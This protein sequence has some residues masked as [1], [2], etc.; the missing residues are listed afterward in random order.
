MMEAYI[1]DFLIS[2]IPFVNFSVSRLFLILITLFVRAGTDSRLKAF[3]KV[4]I[5]TEKKYQNK[6]TIW[7]LQKHLQLF[8]FNII[9]NINEL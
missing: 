1:K 8:N 3:K 6:N 4:H 5:M 9:K 2:K 7:W